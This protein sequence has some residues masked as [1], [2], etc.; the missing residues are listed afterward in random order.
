M[1][2]WINRLVGDQNL[3]AEKRFT[4]TNIATFDG[5]RAEP[6]TTWPVEP[7]GLL[8]PVRLMS[9][10]HVSVDLSEASVP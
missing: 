3:P 10:V 6:G 4:R 7:A 1:K 9:S 8:G 2:L 5:F